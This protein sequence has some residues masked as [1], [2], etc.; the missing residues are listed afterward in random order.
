[1]TVPPPQAPTLLERLDLALATRLVGRSQGGDDLL[2]TAQRMQDENYRSSVSDAAFVAGLL[3][4][5]GL[6]VTTDDAMAL[7]HGGHSRFSPLNQ[8]YQMV[9]GFDG[10]LRLLR[11]RAQL[12]RLLDGQLL[13]DLYQRVT[14]GIAR[15]RNVTLRADQPWDA[16]LHVSYPPPGE[17]PALLATFDFEHRYRDLRPWFDRCHPVRQSFRILWRL[18]RIAPFPDFNLPM[19]WLGMC[20]WLLVKGYPLLFPEAADQALLRHMLVGP[21]PQRVAVFEARLLASVGG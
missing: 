8:E 2:A 6:R 13:F 19:A 9:H 10:A 1:M 20:S 3:Q 7:L 16:L 15:F 11:E 14:R 4:L 12:G 17:L 5:R 21:P 18:A